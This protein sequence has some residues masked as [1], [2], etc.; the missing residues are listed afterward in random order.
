MSGGWR[1][2]IDR[3]E[4]PFSVSFDTPIDAAGVLDPEADR[5]R[6]ANLEW[7]EVPPVRPEDVATV[8]ISDDGLTVHVTPGPHARGT[9]YVL[10]PTEESSATVTSEQVRPYTVRPGT[11]ML[12]RTKADITAGTLVIPAAGEGAR[13]A[14]LGDPR[15]VE[16]LRAMGYIE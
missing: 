2:R 16:A 4:H 15:L 7:G 5:A 11:R 6:R 13:L 9:L 3:P 12:G 1:V 14:E 8:T 10:G